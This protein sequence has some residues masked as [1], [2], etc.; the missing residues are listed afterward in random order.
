M[1]SRAHQAAEL[2]GRIAEAWQTLTPAY[3][4]EIGQRAS[5][6]LI[7]LATDRAGAYDF[8]HY[9]RPVEGIAV[10]STRLPMAP[11]ATPETLA[12]MGPHM[13]EAA[14]QL[15]P[16]SRLDVV[17][18]SCTSGTVAVGLD[19]VRQAIRSV[20]PG[21]PVTTPVGDGAS[22]LKALGCRRISFLCPYRYETAELVTG[23]LRDQG[24]EI[25][26]QAT[27]NLD[28]DPDM[29][30]VSS[31]CLIDAGRRAFDPAS[32]GLFISCT[33]LQTMPV[34]AALEQQLGKPVVTSNQA[35]AWASLRAAGVD[36]RLSGRGLLFATC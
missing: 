20:R 4:P 19:K 29:N 16:G 28:G 17:A 10:F 11:V 14:R 15:V 2:G 23:F 36:E 5:I 32:E 22:A 34:V 8:E 21:I 31:Q 1:T 18:Y 26:R 30:R 6:G 24:F 13:A 12:A 25:I 9:L 35:L 7:A 3:G 27:F 33:G